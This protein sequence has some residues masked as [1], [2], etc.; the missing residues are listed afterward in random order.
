MQTFLPYSDFEKTARSLDYRRLGKQR[1]ETMQ[2]LKALLGQGTLLKNGSVRYAR[3]PASQ[4]W[5]GFES[6][7]AMY[8]IVICTEWTRRGYKDTVR[9]KIN[10]LIEPTTV[11]PTWLGDTNFHRAHQSNLIRKNSLVYAVQ[12]PDVPN[13]LPYLWPK[14]EVP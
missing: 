3:H 12:F 8:G 13:D 11:Y 2:I 14:N 7:L 10:A 6:G 5:K 9:D 1:V 4:M